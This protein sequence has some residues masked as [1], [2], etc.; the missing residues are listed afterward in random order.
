M[1]NDFRGLISPG[2]HPFHFHK[3]IH[4]QHAVLVA[5]IIFLKLKKCYWTVYFIFRVSEMKTG[6]SGVKKKDR[7]VHSRSL[8]FPVKVL[9]F[10]C[11]GFLGSNPLVPIKRFK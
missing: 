4:F 7:A 11:C 3:A 1:I 10:S 6:S 8:E 5:K 9:A 2:H